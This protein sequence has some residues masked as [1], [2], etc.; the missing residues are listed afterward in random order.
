MQVFDFNL[1]TK[2]MSMSRRFNLINEMLVP[3]G[4][5]CYYAGDFASGTE[6]IA[7]DYDNQKIITMFWNSMYFLNK[8]DADK[9]TNNNHRNYNDYQGMMVEN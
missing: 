8:E 4:T 6:K 9:V 7:V 5:K 2:G 3:I 1:N